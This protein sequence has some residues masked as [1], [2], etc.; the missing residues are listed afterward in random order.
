VKKVTKTG[1]QV[2]IELMKF[3][4]DILKDDDLIDEKEPSEVQFQP[5]RRQKQARAL[6][7]IRAKERGIALQAVTASTAVELTGID[8][9]NQWFT[10][11]FFIEWVRREG[12]YAKRV[13]YLLARHLDNLE[14]VIEDCTGEL[15]LR[16]KLAAGDQLLKIRKSLADDESADTQ[17]DKAS[18][19]KRI[20]SVMLEK[21][22]L[23]A[24]KTDSKPR[25][26]ELQLPRGSIDV[27]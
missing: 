10:N 17:V 4:D 21:K 26:K 22:K 13:D 3:E 27:D 5:T 9:F 25:P 11:E 24:A 20:A 7:S 15:D 6:L 16:A 14:E 8:L 19:A 12:D 2:A 23:E 1:E 18:L